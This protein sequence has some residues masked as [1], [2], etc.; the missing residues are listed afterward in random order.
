MA[1]S[2]RPDNDGTG[3]IS[4]IQKV[5]HDNIY[6][7]RVPSYG[8]TV[9]YSFGLILMT[10]LILLTVSGVVMLF[11]GQ[12]WWLTNPVGVYFRSVHMWATQA[13]LLFLVFHM[14]VTFSTSAF[15]KRK[16]VW[17][18]GS[19]MLFIIF[20]Q[21]EL[22]YGIRGDFS[23]QWRSLQGADFWNGNPFGAVL[24]TLN[25]GQIVGVHTVLVP[26]LLL[27]LASTHYLIVRTRGLA[28]PY[29]KDIEYKMVE[30]DHTVLYI[31][32]GAVVAVILLLAL[33][34]PSPFIAP[35]TIQEVAQQNPGAVAQTLILEFNRTSDTATYSNTVNPYAF[36]TRE[37]FVS[38]PYGQY[39]NAS[40]AADSL[41][42]F[43]SQ[44]SAAQQRDI[45]DAYDYFSTNTTSAPA[46]SNPLVSVTG[47]LVSIAQ[48]GV[49]E[50]QLRSYFAGNDQTYVNRFLSD[51]GAMDEKAGGLGLSLED[52]GMLKD[53]RGGGLLPP[54]SWWM[55]PFNILD[56]TLLKG[57]PNQDRDGGEIIGLLSLVLVSLPWLPYVREIPDALGLYK[58]FWRAKGR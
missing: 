35:L 49:Y 36:D 26:L 45:E 25:F 18:L 37:V 31:R 39:V 3:F 28:K 27:F 53:E 10:C 50:A 5:L 38:V 55:A 13:L 58:L 42:A 54:N 34:V 32:G 4:D 1:N 11:F 52:Y 15:R 24:N 30:A 7:N 12:S 2:S 17:L 41:A 48:S 46:S 16:L 23:S 19:L 57:D 14:F 20:V 33:F 44:G 8:N 56:N 29:R 22:G 43:Y 21:S 9:F 6:M 40:G 47:T 51:T